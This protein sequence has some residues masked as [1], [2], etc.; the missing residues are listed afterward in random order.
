MGTRSVRTV[1]KKMKHVAED[2]NTSPHMKR[3]SL[4]LIDESE[5]RNQAG[6]STSSHPKGKECTQAPIPQ[7]ELEAPEAPKVSHHLL[8][9]SNLRLLFFSPPCFC[10]VCDACRHIGQCLHGPPPKPPA[11]R[12]RSRPVLPVSLRRHVARLKVSHSQDPLSF[13]I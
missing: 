13:W 10:K 2:D 6:P 11:P 4:Q 9:L 5:D 3:K 8:V 1:S 12:R 7:D